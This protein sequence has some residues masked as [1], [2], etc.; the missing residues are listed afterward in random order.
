MYMDNPRYDDWAIIGSMDD[1]SFIDVTWF[2]YLMTDE[3]FRTRWDE[4]K[5]DMTQ[6]ADD[7]KPKIAAS[8]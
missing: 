6:A 4:V 7:L 2:N 1:G 8:A 5:D 3:S